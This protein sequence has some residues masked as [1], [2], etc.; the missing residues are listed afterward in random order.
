MSSGHETTGREVAKNIVIAAL[1][2]IVGYLCTV[3][4][5]I[6]NER[7]AMAVGMCYD[8]TRQLPDLACVSKAQTRTSPF[9]HL[10]Y[11]IVD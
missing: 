4:V 2:L 9:W 3:I 1:V 10:F 8:K 6:E 11:A 5:K 7:Y